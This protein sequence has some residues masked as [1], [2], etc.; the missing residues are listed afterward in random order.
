MLL[1]LPQPQVSQVSKYRCN[2]SIKEDFFL[3]HS[4]STGT[5]ENNGGS[6]GCYQHT[7]RIDDKVRYNGPFQG[8]RGCSHT[9]CHTSNGPFQGHRGCSHTVCPTSNGPFQDHSCSHTVRSSN[10]PYQD[11]SCSHTYVLLVVCIQI[12]VLFRTTNPVSSRAFSVDRYVLKKVLFRTT[13]VHS[14]CTLITVLFRTTVVHIP[15]LPVTVLFRTRVVHIRYVLW[16][17][18][19]IRTTVV[20]SPCPSLTALFRATVVHSPY[21]PITALFRAT[22]VHRPYALITALFRDT[23]L[24]L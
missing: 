17:K 19:L 21:V 23:M 9:V 18:V 10:G 15:Y 7:H 5:Q 13:V 2:I 14:P 8:H 1:N 4:S 3:E 24:N 16:V 20:H 6:H 22:V 11:H 12:T